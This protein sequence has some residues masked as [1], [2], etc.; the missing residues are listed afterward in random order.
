MSLFDFVKGIT[1]KFE[2]NEVY[3][4]IDQLRKFLTGDLGAKYKDVAKQFARGGFDS[5]YAKKVTDVYVSAI[6][7]RRPTENYLVYTSEVLEKMAGHTK[8]LR[9]LAATHLN[10]TV[11]KDGL[12]FTA[13]YLLQVITVADFV[14]EYASR[15]LYATMANLAYQNSKGDTL[16]APQLV[17]AE[18]SWLDDNCRAFF[19]ALKLFD[20]D[21]ATLKRKLNSVPDM[22]PDM[23]DF[24]AIAETVGVYTLDPLGVGFVETRQGNP[25]LQFRL[26]VAN[27][28]VAKYRAM[29]AEM[30]AIELR[31]LQLK[32]Q[33]A[34]K[35]DPA[36]DQEV[37]YA[38]EHL[39]SLY[40]KKAKLDEKYGLV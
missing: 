14:V 21:S 2:R 17:P 27:R 33:T 16:V 3:D 22:V 29:E 5:P 13:S 36:V 40:S 1:Q 6:N 15:N 8:V 23:A 24:Q 10:N 26:W 19:T 30:Q 12:S 11:Q 35:P 9:E 31:L 38:E 28:Q 37:R 32:Y 39:S 4:D 18:I 34:G 20:V 7:D 25:L